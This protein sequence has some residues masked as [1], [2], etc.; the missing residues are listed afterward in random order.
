MNSIVSGHAMARMRQRG[1]R[2]KDLEFV[3]AH[4][5]P[6]KGGVILSA[7]DRAKVERDAKQAIKAAGRLAN[8]FV[9]CADDGTVLTTF[10]ATKQQIH[11]KLHG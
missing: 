6:V 10:H 11:R 2:S 9:A 8:V 5:T 3:L 1:I 4:G 7:K